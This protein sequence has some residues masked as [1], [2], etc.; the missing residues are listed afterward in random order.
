[1]IILRAYLTFIRGGVQIIIYFIVF[2]NSFPSVYQLY[3]IRHNNNYNILYIIKMYH[4]FP[5]KRIDIVFQYNILIS[6]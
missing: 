1:M 6:E 2:K 3:N 4:H 5:R